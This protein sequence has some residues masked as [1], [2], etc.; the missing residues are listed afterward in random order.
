MD[1][2]KVCG[3]AP[4]PWLTWQ[5]VSRT[6]FP[7]HRPVSQPIALLGDSSKLFGGDSIRSNIRSWGRWTYGGLVS[8]NLACT[9]VCRD[10]Q[11]ELKCGFVLL[12]AEK[13]GNRSEH[14][15]ARAIW[16]SL[17]FRAACLARCGRIRGGLCVF[18]QDVGVSS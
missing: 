8:K 12:S 4:F 3:G 2:S 14:M 18:Y 17:C 10:E 1:H 16:G 7:G 11:P 6:S 15:G 13:T 9:S 5:P